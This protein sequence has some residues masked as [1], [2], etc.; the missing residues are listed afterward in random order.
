M[1]PV[2]T[3]QMTTWDRAAGY[4]L[5]LGQRDFKLSNDTGGGS[6]VGILQVQRIDF[7]VKAGAEPEKPKGFWKRLF[8]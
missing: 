1:A 4:A 8:G 2:R 5:G 6:M 3:G 7:D